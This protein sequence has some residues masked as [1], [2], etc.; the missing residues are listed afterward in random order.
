MKL[1]YDPAKDTLKFPD[2]DILKAFSR[3][4]HNTDWHKIVAWLKRQ[5]IATAVESTHNRGEECQW[6]GGQAQALE[7]LLDSIENADVRLNKGKELKDK[8][9]GQ[10]V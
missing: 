1:T 5:H 7:M 4:E 3:L 2:H 8:P 9:K 10:I 6:I